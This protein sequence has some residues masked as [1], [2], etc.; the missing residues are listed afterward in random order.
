[1]A[2]VGIAQ[3]YG[4]PTRFLDWTQSS[5]IA[6]YFCVSSK[7][8]VD[9]AVYLINPLDI[10]LKAK[11]E[12]RILSSECDHKI[13]EKYLDLDAKHSP[14]GQMPTIAINPIHNSERV[15]L[16]RGA[17]TVH[18]NKKFHLDQSQASSLVEIN[19][20]ASN[21][22]RLRKGLVRIGID[23]M[24]IFPEVEHISKHLKKVILQEGIY[25]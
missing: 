20:A 25:A 9:G 18:G 1:M 12:G 6:L 8:N 19:I 17:F 14:K 2:W 22:E 13:I 3:H 4:L 23:R 7:E 24:S 5:A 10:N 21:K 15:M 11:N 16:Q